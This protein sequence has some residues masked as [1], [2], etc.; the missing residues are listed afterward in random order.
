[1]L[2]LTIDW[3]KIELE[4]MGETVTAEVR[5]LNPDHML[6]LSPFVRKMHTLDVERAN[7]T[8]KAK[9]D[10]AEEKQLSDLMIDITRNNLD[11]QKAATPIYADIIRNIKGIQVNGSDLKPSYLGGEAAL[12]SLATNLLTEA[13]IHTN[14][15]K[16]SEKNLPS[17]SAEKS[18]VQIADR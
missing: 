12:C 2:I 3:K 13:L 17:V 9:R 5:P 11:M 10:I 18:P 6:L 1:M 16:E 15:D 7:L 14:L 8:K 4:F